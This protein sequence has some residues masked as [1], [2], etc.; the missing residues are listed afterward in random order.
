MNDPARAISN[1]VSRY[2]ELMDHGD[3]AGVGQLF[4]HAA[5]TTDLSDE[6][7]VGAA[8]AQEQFET[9]TRRY[10]DNGTNQ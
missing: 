10:P 8:L 4:R 9:W 2:A 3:F 1:L 7:R 6:V 5:I